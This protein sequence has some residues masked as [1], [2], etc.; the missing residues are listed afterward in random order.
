MGKLVHFRADG[1]AAEVKLDRQRITIGRRPDNDFCLP[2]PAVS[3]E[4]AAVVTILA[5]SFLEDLGSTNGTL[6]NGTAVTKH[7]LRDR[8]EIDVGQQILIYVVDDAATLEPPRRTRKPAEAAG[9]RESAE[10]TLAVPA[11]LRAKR[12]SDFGAP[13]PISLTVA[14]PAASVAANGDDA[15]P[16]E[17]PAAVAAAPPPVAPATSS[18]PGADNA[19]PAPIP[20][21]RHRIDVE[22][23]LKVVS[24]AKAGR[25]VA[26]VK[27]ETLIGRPG[28]QVVAQR[29][30]PD[31]LRVV[32]VEGQSLPS[33]NG[34]AVV[35]EGRSLAVGDLLEVA[36]TK[37]EVVSTMKRTSG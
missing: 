25:I 26:L 13:A 7:F 17:S 10:A 18:P 3:G 15:D 33:V 21:S 19:A 1:S 32:P 12:R 22:P 31:E 4:H 30:T 20:P 2:Y 14:A 5:D 9:E 35:P 16:A 24:G 29:R 28:I 37:L 23:A 27:D 36:G 34:V 8:D 6:V 11:A